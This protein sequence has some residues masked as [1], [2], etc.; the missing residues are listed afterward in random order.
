MRNIYAS[1]VV[2]AALDTYLEIVLGYTAAIYIPKSFFDYFGT[3]SGLL[4]VNFLTITI[5]YFLGSLLLLPLLGFVAKA[6]TFK[7]SLITLAGFIGIVAW[8]SVD[9]NYFVSPYPYSVAFMVGLFSIPLA[10][11]IVSRHHVHNK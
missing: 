9:S 11:W 10:G 6:E 1:L 2:A 4:L 3:A 7:Y 8:R 5:P